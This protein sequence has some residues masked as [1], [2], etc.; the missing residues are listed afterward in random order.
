MSELSQEIKT[1]Q[2]WNSSIFAQHEHE[3][4]ELL[5]NET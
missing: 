5:T 1:S 2:Q 3:M 4:L